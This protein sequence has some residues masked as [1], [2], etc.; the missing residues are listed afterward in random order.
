M[1]PRPRQRRNNPPTE[2]CWEEF[3]AAKKALLQKAEEWELKKNAFCRFTSLNRVGRLDSLLFDIS[4]DH[5]LAR[6]KW[7]PLGYW[8]S[9]AHSAI[10]IFFKNLSPAFISNQG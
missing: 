1:N 6:F 9:I 7:K 3:T 2:I 10:R 5:Y 4:W 8:I